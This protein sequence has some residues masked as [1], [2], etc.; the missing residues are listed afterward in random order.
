MKEI[1]EANLSVQTKVQGEKKG[2]RRGQMG[3]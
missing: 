3:P 2:L 1:L